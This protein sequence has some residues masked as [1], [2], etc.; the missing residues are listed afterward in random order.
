MNSGFQ[1]RMESNDLESQFQHPQSENEEKAAVNLYIIHKL[2]DMGF[3][4]QMARNVL[5]YDRDRIGSDF[6]KAVSYCLKTSEGWKHTFIPDERT[7]YTIGI[8]KSGT[9]SELS[10][11]TVGER[12]KI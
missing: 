5:I 7:K 2:V 3:D 6:M 11:H 8:E 1:S 4:R 10:Y 9:E 12:C